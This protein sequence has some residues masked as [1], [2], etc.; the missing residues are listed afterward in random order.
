MKLFSVLLT[1]LIVST[2]GITASENAITRE[3]DEDAVGDDESNMEYDRKT[4]VQA[5]ELQRPFSRANPAYEVTAIGAG[6]G[7]VVTGD[8]G[9]GITIM[10]GSK[11]TNIRHG[12]QR[13][14]T[15]CLTPGWQN[16]V[17]ASNDGVVKVHRLSNEGCETLKLEGT[18]ATNT[19][20]IA[21]LTYG[22]IAAESPDGIR[23]WDLRQG[24]KPIYLLRGVHG[25]I[26][27]IPTD[28]RVSIAIHTPDKGVI[29]IYAPDYSRR[30]ADL[31]REKTASYVHFVPTPPKSSVDESRTLECV[32]VSP[33]ANYLASV[34]SHHVAKLWNHA[35]R[36]AKPLAEYENVQAVAFCSDNETMATA[37]SVWTRIVNIH[38]Q[39]PL[40]SLMSFNTGP[41]VAM[42][43]VGNSIFVRILGGSGYFHRLEDMQFEKSFNHITAHALRAGA[44]IVTTKPHQEFYSGELRPVSLIAYGDKQTLATL[45]ITNK[46][47]SQPKEHH[48]SPT[49]MHR[50]KGK[51]IC[52]GFML[53]GAL[54]ALRWYSELS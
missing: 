11:I 20:K 13:I 16:I 36:A 34:C 6:L 38:S 15:I 29:D 2:F 46:T 25:T 35:T 27:A 30:E 1:V 42:D 24:T 31:K 19:K 54:Q 8:S 12:D 7:M 51:I 3:H 48:T 17:S 21:L 47:W 43:F 40:V 44:L 10:Q 14:H 41:V 4:R 22:Y 5:T 49:F 37:N 32:T 39:K 53:L 26:N 45:G 28:H 52:G 33:N 50:H 9:G 23:L 18:E